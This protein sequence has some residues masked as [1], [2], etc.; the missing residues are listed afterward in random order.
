MLNGAGPRGPYRASRVSPATIVGSANG[1]SMIAFTA[2]L[3]RKSSRTSTQ[4]IRVPISALTNVTTRASASV[5]FSAD[6]ASRSV[7]ESQKP[8]SPP[9]IDFAATAASGSST[10]KLKN[11]MATPRP[12]AAPPGSETARGRE[13]TTA[14]SAVGG[15]TQAL[16]DL[17]HDALVLVEELVRHHA[18]TAELGDRELILRRGELLRV[19]EALDDRAIALLRED[20]LRGVGPEVVHERLRL[21]GALRVARDRDRVL[22]QDRLVGDH[23]VE[24][25][26]LLLGGDR[27]VLVGDQ[28]VA[29]A[30]GERLQ[31]VAGGLV[32][33]RHVLEELL[34]VVGGLGLALALGDLAA[35]RRHHVPARAAR[36]ERVRRD[37]L[38]ARL[39]QVAPPL[40]VLRVALAD[41]EHHDGVSDHALVGVLVPALVHEAGVHEAS[42]V[43]LERE[44]DDVGAQAALD[45]A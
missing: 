26:A 31:R 15:D 13:G 34:E 20:L 37:D 43:R 21:V 28:N 45:G 5:N 22:D 27:L 19:D 39:G 12:S 33:H 10:M 25:L 3:P 18:P 30:A 38:D 9:S 1:R 40:D 4:A 36:G 6:I 11:S 44:R 35:V 7:T 16:L 24:L 32:L 42:H 14:A 8:A 29:L 23:V 2:P 41:R 17:G